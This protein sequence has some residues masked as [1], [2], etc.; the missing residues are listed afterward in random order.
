MSTRREFLKTT[1]ATAAGLAAA[2]MP[3]YG[4]ASASSDVYVGKGTAEKVIP[5]IFGKLGGIERF[6]KKGSRVLIKP[7]ISFANPPEWGTGTSPQALYAVAKLCVDAGAKR[8]VICDNT[9]RDPE[10]CKE[11]TGAAEAVRQL[12]NV[13]LFIPRQASMFVEKTH[14]RATALK[15]TDIVKELEQT[16]C[17]ISLPCAKSHSAAG[18]SLSLK[19]NMG[20]LRKRHLLHS[21]MDLHTAI[22]EMQYYMRQHVTIIDATRALIDNGPAG[23]GTVEQLDTFVGS[24][25]PVAADSYGVTLARWYG[26]KFEGTNVEHLKIAEKLGF[27]NCASSRIKEVAV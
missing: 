24:T 14:P 27:G 9:L 11:K 8:V 23:P 21:A 6:V 13:V 10:L 26:R 22:A 1:S 18:V 2:V 17:F 7:N 15:R 4:Q 5:R 16:D 20:L 3:V 25:D 19:G 12:R